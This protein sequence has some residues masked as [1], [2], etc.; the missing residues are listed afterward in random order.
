MLQATYESSGASLSW[1]SSWTVRILC[2]TL[3]RHR[4]KC[5]CMWHTLHPSNRFETNSNRYQ[6][7]AY[8]LERL[9]DTSN[10]YIMLGFQTTKAWWRIEINESAQLDDLQLQLYFYSTSNFN[11]NTTC[12]N[13]STTCSWWGGRII[14][15]GY[16]LVVVL[17]L[18][19]EAAL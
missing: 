3:I 7:A 16:C 11:L 18:M 13:G 15:T 17:E 19:L 6:A 5:V 8:S 10:E 1:Q 9:N 12:T 14:A 4:M 2:C